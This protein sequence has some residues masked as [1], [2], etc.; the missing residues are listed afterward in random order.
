MKTVVKTIRPSHGLLKPKS[1]KPRRRARADGGPGRQCLLPGGPF[2]PGRPEACTGKKVAAQA[3][4]ALAIGGFG[5]SRRGCP[6]RCHHDGRQAPRPPERPLS[7]H[8]SPGSQARLPARK[9]LPAAWGAPSRLDRWGR[10]SAPRMLRRLTG[11]QSGWSHGLCLPP[12]P[13]GGTNRVAAKPRLKTHL[14]PHPPAGGRYGGTLKNVALG[15][16]SG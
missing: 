6:K 3:V 13:Q 16:R 7:S 15:C 9:P 5:R 12:S 2:G 11:G 14:S 4:M 8:A 10:S 1:R